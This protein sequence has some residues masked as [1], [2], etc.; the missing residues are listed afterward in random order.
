M[1]HSAKLLIGLLLVQVNKLKY[2]ESNVVFSDVD[3]I[4]SAVQAINLPHMA[5]KL[6]ADIVDK[7]KVKQVSIYYNCAY[8]TGN[9]TVS[10][11]ILLF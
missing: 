1:Q 3:L 8:I 11:Y 2:I 9:T 5:L 6:L 10:F 4:V 7:S